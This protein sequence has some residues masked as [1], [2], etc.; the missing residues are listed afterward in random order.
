MSAQARTPTGNRLLDRLPEEVYAGL[1]TSL[2]PVALSLKQNLHRA[3]DPLRDVYFPRRGV[4]SLLVQT[5]DGRKVEVATIGNEGVVGV[6]AALGLDRAPLQATC[7]VPGE[8][9]R[10]P[11][12]PFLETAGRVP[13]FAELMRRYAGVYF[14]CAAQVA[15]C[16][17]LHPVPE[18]LCR[19]LL[20]AHDSAGADEFPLTQ[21]FL[22]DMLGV[23]RQTVSV[24]AGTLQKAG[25]IHY[26]RGV[27]RVLDRPGLEDACCECY[28]VM[29]GYSDQTMG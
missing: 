23:R 29:K 3:G 11:V 7:Q 26:R 28:R 6:T 5:E 16:N 27:L 8:A 9:L 22:A 1:A 13:A 2:V 18:R 10:L 15:A 17:A 21:E 14:R 20:A 19:W 12:G 25:L 4:V 24:V